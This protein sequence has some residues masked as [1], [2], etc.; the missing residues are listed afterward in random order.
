MKRDQERKFVKM[1]QRLAEVD[2]GGVGRGRILEVEID[3]YWRI[4][5]QLGLAKKNLE[6]TCWAVA[7]AF[8][9]AKISEGRISAH[10]L[11]VVIQLMKTNQRGHQKGLGV[12]L[13]RVK[14]RFAAAVDIDCRWKMEMRGAASEAGSPTPAVSPCWSRYEV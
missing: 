6:Q 12:S 11:R 3:T 14:L 8:D 4:R 1:D 9:P 2:A 7:D 10:L 5:H 13:Q